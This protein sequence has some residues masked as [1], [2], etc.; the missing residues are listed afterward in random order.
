MM[1][2]V[3]NENHLMEEKQ[4][5][6]PSENKK[7]D[8]L[9]KRSLTETKLQPLTPEQIGPA[10]TSL[11]FTPPRSPKTQSVAADEK[12]ASESKVSFNMFSIVCYRSGDLKSH[13]LRDR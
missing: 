3:A 12:I 1:S 7:Y 6:S 2:A 13:L 11:K 8:V 5:Q 4:S 9:S 10:I